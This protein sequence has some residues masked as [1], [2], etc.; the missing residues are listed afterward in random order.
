MSIYNFD[1]KFVIAI[2]LSF[3]ISCIFFI[4]IKPIWILQINKK[5]GTQ[6]IYKPLLF[7][8]SFLISLIV[9][10]TTLCF[11]NKPKPNLHEY[12]L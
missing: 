11:K 9:G 8:Y 10:I 3:L 1:K 5:T 12:G 6:S 7:L 2:S 4:I